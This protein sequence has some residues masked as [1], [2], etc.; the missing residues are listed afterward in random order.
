MCKFNMFITAVCVLFLIKL[1]WP[2]N[3]SIYGNLYFLSHNYRVHIILFRLKKNYRKEKRYR[4]KRAK[5]L[6]S[7]MQIF[8][9]DRENNDYM[10]ALRPRRFNSPLQKREGTGASFLYIA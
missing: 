5:K 3:K 1:R 7:G 4:W 9:Y 10:N 6:Y 8:N 2:K